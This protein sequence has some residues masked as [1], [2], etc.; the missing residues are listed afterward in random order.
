MLLYLKNEQFCRRCCERF[1]ESIAIVTFRRFLASFL[2][3]FEMIKI[4]KCFAPYIGSCSS[5]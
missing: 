5:L 2:Y 1:V 3:T 4:G